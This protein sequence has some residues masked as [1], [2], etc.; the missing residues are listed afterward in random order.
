MRSS[1]PAATNSRSSGQTAV[2]SS[3]GSSSAGEL[4]A[5]LEADGPGAQALG[6]VVVQVVAAALARLVV[7][8]PLLAGV[9]EHEAPP[10]PARAVGVDQRERVRGE[11]GGGGEAGERLGASASPGSA[12]F[13]SGWAAR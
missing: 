8:D 9:R 5:E 4:E 12:V 13:A 7:G 3:S 1:L 10:R 6:E 2:G 11:V